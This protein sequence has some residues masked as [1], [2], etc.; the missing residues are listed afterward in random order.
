MLIVWLFA[1]W[2]YP[3]QYNN[4]H[5]EC[6]MKVNINVNDIVQKISFLT[7]MI[8]TLKLYIKQYN[9]SQHCKADY[10]ITPPT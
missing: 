3:T 8:N 7:Y 4:R 10:L 5:I 2:I 9:V 1:M 6:D